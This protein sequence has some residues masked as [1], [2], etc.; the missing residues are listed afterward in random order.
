MPSVYLSIF[1]IGKLAGEV[2][3][4]RRTQLVF[5]DIPSINIDQ[6][7]IKLFHTGRGSECKIIWID[8][9]LETV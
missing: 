8:E 6:N 7:K 4:I 9:T 1:I 5:Q 2:L 3:T